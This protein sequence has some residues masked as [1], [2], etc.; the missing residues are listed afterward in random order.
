MYTVVHLD[1]KRHINKRHCDNIL[2]KKIVNKNKM[3]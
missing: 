2:L 1:A 3:K